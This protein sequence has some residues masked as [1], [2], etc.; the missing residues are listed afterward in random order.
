MPGDFQVICSSVVGEDRPS[1]AWTE[2]PEL[3]ALRFLFE[4][5]S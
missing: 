2:T 4:G 3:S 1:P 5:Q